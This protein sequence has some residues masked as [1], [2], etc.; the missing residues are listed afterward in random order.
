MRYVLASA[1]LILGMGG[2]A[3]AAWPTTQWI[4]V[5]SP[6]PLGKQISGGKAAVGERKKIALSYMRNL[7]I[8]GDWFESMGF[9]APYQLN[10]K[11]RFK[12]E[13]QERYKAHLKT[14]PESR[15]SAHWSTGNM[16]LSTHPGF[17]NPKTTTDEL[18]QAA[19]IHELF[20]GIQRANPKYSKFSNTVLHQLPEC[21][22]GEYA[23]DWFTEGSASAVQIQFLERTRQYIYGHPFKDGSRKAWVRV[24][25]QPLDM[26]R[27]P[28][29]HQGEPEV[30]DPLTSWQ[31]TYGTWYFWYAVGNML[32]SID[33]YDL[34]RTAYLRYI[35]EQD[36]PWEGTGIAVVDAGLKLAGEKMNALRVYR[37][38]LYALYPQFV[39]QYLDED[40]FFENVEHVD[41]ATPGLYETTSAYGGGPIEPIATRAWRVRVHLPPD[42]SALPYTVRFVLESPEPSTL[43]GLHLIIDNRVIAHPADP[44]APYSH[45]RRTDEDLLLRGD[46]EYFVR[47]ANVAPNAID[48]HAADFVLRVEV[49]GFY[50]ESPLPLHNE[51]GVSNAAIAAELPPGFE[52]TGPDQHWTCSGG[53]DARAAFTILTPDGHA[54]QLERLLPQALK[55]M[56]SDLDDAEMAAHRE[57]SAEL[58]RIQ[59]ASKEFE[60]GMQAMLEASGAQSEIQQAANESRRKNE[61]TLLIKLYGTNAE[62]PCNVVLTATQDGRQAATGVIQGPNFSLAIH[63]ASV[64]RARADIQNRALAVDFSK[65]DL[66]D[67]NLGAEGSE[68]HTMLQNLRSQMEQVEIPDL[69]WNECNNGERGCKVSEL[70][71]ERAQHDHV[72]GA[73][74]I[75]M[76]RGAEYDRDRDFADVTGFFNIT[77]AHTAGDNSLVDFMSRGERVGEALHT[78]GVERLLPGASLFGK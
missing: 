69:Q 39:G 18:F 50:G 70:S 58:S 34:R 1:A 65:I 28:P 41:M 13:G 71:L 67:P 73:V 38:G 14:D 53:D 68:F 55:N 21:D 33:P 72:S 23:N 60:S 16:H 5:E 40:A 74:T 52:F 49:E 8:G 76:Y 37:G 27:I 12:F 3:H 17:L 56:E 32:G 46:L 42:V 77:S 22:P 59:Q 51:A 44:T 15:S 24:F 26:G 64:N 54:D 48:T 47:V 35:I 66:S 19:A 43:E 63:S 61:T 29:Q 31:C 62:G 45:T 36:G 75:R 2:S 57:G 10:E 4:V 6:V 7:A 78:P 25:D 30:S 20:H 9:S 11:D